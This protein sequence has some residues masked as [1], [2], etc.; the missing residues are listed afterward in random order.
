MARINIGFK[1][2]LTNET[3]MA[4]LSKELPYELTTEKVWGGWFLVLKNNLVSA[5]V[6]VK[7][8]KDSTVIEVR[9]YIH[10]F[11]MRLLLIIF[12][13]IPYYIVSLGPAASFAR[14]ISNFIRTMPNFQ[15]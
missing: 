2:G 14:E 7:Q 12:I 5:A 8:R 4:I 15:V 10:E 11:Y 13:I 6:R 1:P 9:G 3:L